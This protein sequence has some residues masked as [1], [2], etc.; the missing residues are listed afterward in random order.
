MLK[1][2]NLNQHIENPICISRTASLEPQNARR[3]PQAAFRLLLLAYILC[4]KNALGQ[5]F[6]MYQSSGGT[7]V[8]INQGDTMKNPWAGGMLNPQFSNIFL[9]ADLRADI[10]VFEPADG[11]I[12]LFISL[13]DGS[14]RYSPEY[15]SAF[16]KM[17]NWA[18]L[19]DYNK[20]GKADIF[21]YSSRGAGL[22]VYRNISSGNNFA[23]EKVAERL[24]YADIDFN[25]NLY[26]PS[27][28]IPA[29]TDIDNDG[30]LD[31]LS[32]DVLQ[33]HIQYYK[34]LSM[35]KYGVPDS[36]D[37]RIAD[38][39]WGK[40]AESF[41][42]N[43][44]QLGEDCGS[45][46]KREKQHGG[47]TLLAFDKDGDG[48]KDMLLGDVG[49]NNL[50]YLENGKIKNGSPFTR[51]DSMI[52][53]DTIFPRNTQ[54]AELTIFPAAFLVDIN[55][56]GKKDLIVTPQGQFESKTTHQVFAYINNGTNAI[57]KFD[58]L[59]DDFLQNTMVDVGVRSA[60]AFL[61]YNGDS[62]MDLVI[63]VKANP[64]V[65]YRYSSLHL[66]KNIGSATH[67][68]YEKVSEDFGNISSLKMAAL[69]PHFK[70][71]N[72]DAKPDLILGNEAG[73]VVFYYNQGLDANQIPTFATAGISTIDV[74][75]YSKPSA[76]DINRDGLTDL[77]IGE[78]SGN[79]NYY[80]N[81]GSANAP[82]FT[83]VS[84]T[85]GHVV[86]NRFYYEYE[87][88]DS[89]RVVDSTL[90]K[91]PNG[92]SAPEIA[93]MDGDG[94]WDMISGSVYGGLII[95][96]NIEDSLNSTFAKSTYFIYDPLTY[97]NKEGSFGFVSIPAAAD[98]DGDT[99]PELFIGN[100]RGG[101]YYLASQPVILSIA[102]KEKNTVFRPL[103][104]YPNPA[105]KKAYIQVPENALN[106]QYTLRAINALGQVAYIQNVK[107][108]SGKISIDVSSFAPGLYFVTLQQS[109]GSCFSAKLLVE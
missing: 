3:I 15:E 103:Q 85:F 14:F 62:L 39:C 75:Q 83:L 60:P 49:Y 90:V 59:Q 91:E 26:V 56:D 64:E 13:N 81:T 99:K 79:Y 74:G 109:N 28:D 10:F 2:R 40:F 58:F 27:S 102:E 48:D 47:S 98:L 71:I 55:T 8:I 95:F 76:A 66:Y 52:A 6:K 31:I 105:T 34:N 41:S 18:L 36:L 37:Y 7:D 4:P 69:T 11:K 61:D 33:Y 57:P 94:K 23:F 100:Y 24:Q 73:E 87:Y 46:G 29:L 106:Q 16:P 25:L 67:A 42:A 21:T 101:L 30:D 93:D 82:V 77:V 89:G 1:P 65:D 92:A 108:A 70:D 44:V 43:T 80:Q 38:R 104:I 96:F 78:Q 63:S 32:Y 50:I 88:N 12:S 107:N 51:S 86:T 17:Q 20:D 97:K 68:V 54:K 72:G 84:D 22:D 45:V 5:D 35:E 19:A 53:V 9:N